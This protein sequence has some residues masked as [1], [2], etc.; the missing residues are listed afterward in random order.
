L[1]QGRWGWLSL[2]SCERY[3]CLHGME[4][5]LQGLLLGLLL[6]YSWRSQDCLLL[7]G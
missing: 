4:L 1:L 3:R 6:L 2:P 7:L 5:P